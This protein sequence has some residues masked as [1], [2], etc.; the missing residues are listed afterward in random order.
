MSSQK[1]LLDT[2]II[3]DLVR[4]PQGLVAE[5]IVQEGESSICSSIIVASEL[6][7][8]A[9]KK[10]QQTGSRLLMELLELILSAIDILSFETPAEYHYAEIRVFLEQKGIP[11]GANDLL[12]ATHARAN[13]LVMVSANFSE[14]SCVPEL[15][16]DNWLQ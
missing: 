4:N 8:G 11:I 6:R 7:F 5:R 16:V 10:F 9:M 3:S 2:N 13:A 12:I 14:F 1:F 15:M